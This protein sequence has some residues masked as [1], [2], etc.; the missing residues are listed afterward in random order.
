LTGFDKHHI[1][2]VIEFMQAEKK[3]KMDA[4]GNF[5]SNRQ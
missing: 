2:E 1:N 3:I 5:F 4:F